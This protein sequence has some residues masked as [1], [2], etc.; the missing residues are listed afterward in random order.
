MRADDADDQ[1]RRVALSD[2]AQRRVALL[3]AARHFVNATGR[4]SYPSTAV[5]VAVT[6]VLLPTPGGHEREEA[7]GR[8]LSRGTLREGREW[9]REEERVPMRGGA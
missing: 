2:A 6:A 8:R 4:P 3:E 5:A 1:K 7:A 9:D